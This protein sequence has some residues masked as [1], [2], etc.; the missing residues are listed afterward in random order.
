MAHGPINIRFVPLSS[1]LILF[2]SRDV[3]A[4]KETRL[5]AGRPRNYG[6]I[7]LSKYRD[8]SSRARGREA[9]GS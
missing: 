7:V 8:M 1:V 5:R 6:Q 3:S 2:G 9:T 4:G